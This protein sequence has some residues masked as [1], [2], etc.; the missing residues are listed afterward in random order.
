MEVPFVSF[1]DTKIEIT[2][3]W[4]IYAPHATYAHNGDNIGHVFLPLSNGATNRRYFSPPLLIET[5]YTTMEDLSY[6]G[7]A[8]E[9]AWPSDPALDGIPLPR[10][11]VPSGTPDPT[12]LTAT[13]AAAA[14]TAAPS[15]P[16][17]AAWVV[18]VIV[19]ASILVLTVL[20]AVVILCVVR[21]GNALP[22]S[23][24]HSRTSSPEKKVTIF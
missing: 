17:V 16:A 18:A 2:Q 5:G 11:P 20:I 3:F 15:G 19:V 21:R 13:A 22:P 8:Y 24:A 23:P 12:I 7:H 4:L 9:I 14:A 1:N 6:V 10:T